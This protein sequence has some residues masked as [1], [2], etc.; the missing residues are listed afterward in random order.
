MEPV[1]GDETHAPVCWNGSPDLPKLSI[2]TVGL[3]VRLHKAT[4]FSLIMYG[5]DE[6][7][8]QDDPRY[9]V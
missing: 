2:E 3:R 6:P 5:V 7:L 9:P 8:V 4:L 1:T